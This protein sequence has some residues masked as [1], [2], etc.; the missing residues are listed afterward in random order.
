MIST[1]ISIIVKKYNSLAICNGSQFL[2]AFYDRCERRAF[3]SQIEL[4]REKDFQKLYSCS[5]FGNCR[6][7]YLDPIESTVGTVASIVKD[8]L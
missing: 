1:I 4:K 8:G 7:T 5:H 3:S 2:F 6:L